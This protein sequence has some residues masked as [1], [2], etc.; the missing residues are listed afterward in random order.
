[1]EIIATAGA[2]V[3]DDSLEA[4]VKQ[5]LNIDVD[6]FRFNLGKY[7]STEGTWL[8]VN[9][10]LSMK[11]KYGIRLMI[12]IPYPFRKPR[13]FINNDRN[14]I[15][16]DIG[17]S[18]D[19]SYSRNDAVYTDS[20]DIQALCVGDLI[21]DS[22]GE[23]VLC[24]KEKKENCL[25]VE[26]I[27]ECCIFDKKGICFGTL[28]SSQERRGLYRDIVNYLCPTSVALSFVS[29]GVD[30]CAFKKQLK[31]DCEV[32]SKIESCSGIENLLSI[33]AESD[34]MVARGDLMIYADYMQLSENQG[35]IVAASVNAK[36]KVYI[37]TGILNSLYKHSIPT[38][39]EMVDIS[40]IVGLN[41]Y[42]IILNGSVVRNNFEKAVEI[43]RRLL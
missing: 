18:F 5:G 14:L 37:A 13:I 9:E 41:P 36:R 19:I 15:E 34:L 43:V 42:G 4:L 27:K 39:A 33:S 31:A 3:K 20:E 11:K 6:Y 23:E 32:I 22:D 24:V 29:D 30:V 12:D 35:K 28:L 17:D 2:S 16:A 10:I 21:S 7:D 38:Q 40:T 26:A 1:M 8:R 25:V